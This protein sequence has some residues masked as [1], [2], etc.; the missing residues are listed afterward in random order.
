[1]KLTIDNKPIEVMER[2]LTLL[3]AAV[4]N[5]VYIPHLCAHP[6]LTPYGGCRLCI[7]EVEGMRGYPTACTTKIHEGMK[8]QTKTPILQDMRREIIQLILSEHPTGCLICDEA[9]E[10]KDTMSTIRKVGTTTGCRWCPKDGDCELQR[11]VEYLD[12]H[13]IKFPV[14]YQNLDV[15]KYD[16]FFDRDY[17]LC[18][19]CG[20]CVRICEEHR[21]SFV[22]TLSERGKDA[23]VGPAFHLSHIDAECEF[24]GACVSVCPTG[25]LSEKIRKWAGVPKEYKESVCPFCGTNCDIQLAVRNEK[26]IGTIPP[27]DPRQ[28]G[29][30]LCVKG[31]FTLAGLLCHPDRL[32]EPHFKFPEGYGIV[33]WEEA[34]EKAAAQFNAVKGKRA[35][36]YL[37]PNLPLEEIIALNRFAT[38]VMETGNITSS[39]LDENMARFIAAA[40]ISIPLEEIEESGALVTVFLKGNY[41]YG[42]LTLAIKRAAQRGVPL[43]QIGWT[44]DNSTRYA[45]QTITPPPG[46]EKS[47]FKKLLAAIE[48]G[49]GGTGEMKKLV[50]MIEDSP[51]TTFILSPEIAGLTEAKEILESIERIVELTAGK[52]FAPSP[53]SNISGLLAAA[54]LELCEEI[55]RMVTEEKIDLLYIVGDSPF[56]T[57]PPV[58]FIIHQAA[59]PPPNEL[60]ADL[61]LPAALWGEVPGTYTGAFGKRK[62]FRAAVK[63]P[64]LA[65]DNR[66]IVSGIVKAMGRSDTG[67]TPEEIAKCIP[68]NFSV[69]LPETKVKTRKAKVTAPDTSYPY[70]LIQERTPHAL[71]NVSLSKVI[72]DLGVLLPE[73]TL[74]MN[75]QDAERLGLAE[76]DGVLVES[77]EKESTFPLK[78]QQIIAPGFVFLLTYRRGHVFDA[79]PCPVHLRRTNV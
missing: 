38:D 41:A 76:G 18:I 19:Y 25:T 12:I 75:P 7:V 14:Y 13:E 51:S 40:E 33:S 50:Q 69:T 9:Q 62:T 71:H 77:L 56:T 4:K 2:E 35:A 48:K 23:R 30:E 45:E 6:E 49:T 5:D 27:G 28:S 24:C 54:D 10:C 64:G 53:Y 3:D 11:V 17:N 22:L 58:D 15:E 21:K 1:M 60:A 66:E 16:P 20:R 70:L 32:L 68:A 46:N 37:S 8:V 31:R 78:L 43:I 47:F 79:N 72:A 26:I 36:L 29:G 74:L 39:I 67:Y 57:R 34:L 61:L 73:D 65:L 42:P 59:F 52:I 63:T 55:D 44:R